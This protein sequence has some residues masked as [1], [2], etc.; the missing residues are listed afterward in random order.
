MRSPARR[1]TRM[2]AAVLAVLLLA[3]A[4]SG[5]DDDKE[6]GDDSSPPADVPVLVKADVAA[7]EVHGHLTKAVR[8]RVV[9]N[10]G[11][12]VTTW[13]DRAYLG[14][15]PRSDFTHAFPGFTPGA[16]R[17]ARHDRA[18]M[19]NAAI[20]HEIKWVAARKEK[21]RVDILAVRRHA[22]AA[23]ARFRL[24]FVTSAHRGRP[25]VVSGRVMLT[26]NDKGRWRIFGYDVER[27][28][29]HHGGRHGM[30]HHAKGHHPKA[31][32]RKGGRR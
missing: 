21:V 29:L 12:V 18:L 22:A 23:T 20:G 27:A 9:H 8:Q 2:A 19:S 26:K 7:G 32:H 3:P 13:L 28:G 14:D 5:D 6:S 30:G 31:H 10:V 11:G 15:Y 24:V 1:P 25:V 16:V 4:C 17:L